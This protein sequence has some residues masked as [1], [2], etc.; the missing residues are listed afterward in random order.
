MHI[1]ERKVVSIHYVLTDDSGTQIDAS[2]AG[3]PLRYLHG[4]GNIIPGLEKALVGLT[5][6]DKKTVVVAPE[7]GYGVH[8]PDL[9]IPVPRTQ[10]GDFDPQV[11]MQVQAD[12]PE[13]AML[14]TVVEANQLAVTLDANHPL[15]G[16]TLHF[17]VTVAAVRDANAQE[18]QQG[19]PQ[20]NL[21][22][23]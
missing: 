20:Q 17:D 5:S 6:G 11:G 10:F 13:G 2:P 4:G 9:V 8:L 12:T 14:F 15:A 22:T 16:V 18:I 21:I 19:Y 7:D 23:L 1:A 3:E